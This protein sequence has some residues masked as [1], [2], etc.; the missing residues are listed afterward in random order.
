MRVPTSHPKLFRGV[1]LAAA[2]AS[3]LLALSW[4]LRGTPSSAASPVA[5]VHVMS[6]GMS[7]SDDEMRAQVAAHFK[8]HPPRAAVATSAPTDSFLA[9]NFRFDRDG[10]AATQ[11]DTAHIVAGES[12]RFK[13]GTGFH[14]VTSGNGSGDQ[15]SGVLFDKPM[16]TTTDKFDFE[17]DTPG[18]YIF[19]CQIHEGSNMFGVIEVSAP[20]DVPRSNASRIGFVQAPWPNPTKAGASF[21]FALPRAGDVRIEV[22]DAQGR[23]VA[24]PVHRAFEAGTFGGSWD[25]RNTAGGAATAGVYYLRLA[26]P[27]VHQVERVTIER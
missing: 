3:A 13:W 23:L 26:A 24:T 19:Y 7:M 6:G 18:E 1:L 14:T 10:S 2:A 17:F 4:Q 27:G 22:F 5:G 15:N 12:V 11:V 9:V 21:R 20:L 25:G 8:L 16:T